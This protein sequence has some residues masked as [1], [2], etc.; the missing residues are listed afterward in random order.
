MEAAIILDD[1]GLFQDPA[2][3]L[4][5][6]DHDIKAAAHSRRMRDDVLIDPRDGVADLGFEFL[7]REDKLV[8]CKLNDFRVRRNGIYTPYHRHKYE[9]I[10][11]RQHGSLLTSTQQ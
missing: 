9:E 10:P 8:D 1:A 3:R 11:S 5:R 4:I 7:R 6:L 2:C